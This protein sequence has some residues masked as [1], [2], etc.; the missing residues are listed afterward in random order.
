MVDHLRAL[1]RNIFKQ[2]SA[3]ADLDEE[4]RGYLEMTAAEKVRWGMAPEEALR[5]ARRELGGVE[6]V[7]QNVRDIRTGVSMDTLMQDVRYA[8]RTLSRNLA[9]SSVVVLTLALGIGANTAI[10]T[11]VDGV[12][13]KPLPYPEPDRLL[14]LW[15]SS[16]TDRNLGT[17]APANFYDWREQSHSFEKMAAIDP[18]PDFILNGS[19]Q[20]RRM[21]GAAVSHDFFSLLGIHMAIGRDFLAEEDHPGSN[22]V[23][24]LSYSTWQRFF[25]GRTAIVGSVVRLNDADYTVIGVL[26]RDFSFVSKA[27]DYQSRNRFDLWTPLA[28]GS[29]PEEWQRNTQS[30]CVFARLKP[31]I[32]LRQAQTDLTQVA[33][34]LQRLYPAAD[35]GIGITAV[36]LGQYVVGGVRTAMITLQAAVVMVLL[37][38]CANIANL[39]LTRA[40]GRRKEIALRVALGASRRRIARQLI[41]ECMVLAVSGGLLGLAFALLTVPA[42]VHHLPADLPRASEIAVDWRVLTFTSLLSILTGIVFGLVPLHQSRRVNANDSLKQG[43]RSV[44]S[45]QSR[46]RSPLIVGQVAVTLVLLSGAGLMTKSLWKLTRVS[47]GFQTERILTARLSLPPQYTNGYKYGMGQH[48]EITTFQRKLLDRIRQIPG[49]QSAAFTSNLPLSGV[50]NS[51]SFDIEGRPLKPAGV[52]D[53]TKYRP[54]SAGYFETI[55]IPIQR[56]R[57]FEAGD[58]E[59]RPL[60]V[61]VNESMARRFWGAANPVGQRV[62]FDNGEWRTIVGVV[63]DVHHEGL[64][65]KPDPEMYV[66]YGQ[67][68][69]VEARPVIVLRTS[70]EPASV[71]SALRKAVADVDANVPMDQVETM[72]QIVY[73]SVGESRFGTILLGLFALL[74][75]FVSAIG[76][77]GVMSYVVSQRTREFGIRMAVGATRGAILRVVLGKAAK[78][79][80]IGICLGLVGAVLLARVIASLLYGV[81]PFDVATLASVSILLASVVLLASF[82]PARRASKVNPMDSLRYE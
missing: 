39:M 43:G 65:A 62:R 27:S 44:V 57:G 3:N 79:V 20:A 16:L 2:E 31:G 72:K 75:L 10:F 35:K 71:T 81:K 61:A 33:A 53:L 82:V 66:P 55:G 32:S 74:A 9:F 4:V 78:L 17:V 34:N 50:D 14:M 5:E 49:L 1:W 63:G 18:Y 56:G 54:V 60:V 51:R 24:V 58:A 15:E 21:A 77:Y 23:V 8:V 42:V 13:L 64:G 19:G 46:M 38:A 69:N 29:P 52:Y 26:P 59:D 28:L 47:P 70:V 68:P 12:L 37:I 41:T 36:P 40:A 80:S 6:Q 73:G 67:V 48:R 7:K 25:G 76:L 30:L 11:I 22:H 45:A